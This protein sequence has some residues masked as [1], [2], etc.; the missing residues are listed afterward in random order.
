MVTVAERGRASARLRKSATAFRTISEASRELNIP[1]HVLRFWE[2]KFSEV[3]PVKRAGGRRY[4]R[5]EDIVL[6]GRIR[7]LLYVDGYTIK[8]VQKLFRER[9]AP[10][11][12]ES[13]IIPSGLS[14]E[15]K[16]MN[17]SVTKSLE[18]SGKREELKQILRELED[19]RTILT[20]AKS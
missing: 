2:S 18:K 11:L 15:T 8:G 16:N 5:R 20:K 19:I 17:Q 9:G 13:E 1:A 14:I 10:K 6:L 12:D 4:Y 3:N 7:D